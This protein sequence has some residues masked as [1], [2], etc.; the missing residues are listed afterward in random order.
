MQDD[1]VGFCDV[2]EVSEDTS[3]AVESMFFALGSLQT[4]PYW[5]MLVLDQYQDGTFRM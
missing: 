1:G 4:V 2:S 5:R 3:V